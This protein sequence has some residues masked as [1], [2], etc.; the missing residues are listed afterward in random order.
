MVFILWRTGTGP[1][2]GKRGAGPEPAA[3]GEVD[4][5]SAGGRMA[6]LSS[7]RLCAGAS[8]VQI[9]HILLI[10]IYIYIVIF[11]GIVIYI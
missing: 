4:V 6:R 3:K 8:I 2:N 10:Y 5:A 11:I 7:P 1:F 9:N